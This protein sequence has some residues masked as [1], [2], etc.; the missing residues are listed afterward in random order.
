MVRPPAGS[1]SYIQKQKRSRKMENNNSKTTNEFDNYFINAGESTSSLSE[2]S[3]HAA[4]KTQ[5]DSQ[6]LPP[7]ASTKDR[8]FA[9]V[10][11]ALGFLLFELVLFEGFGVCVPVYMALFY[12]A[13]FWYFNGKPGGINAKS[14]PLLI[15]IALLLVCYVL[16]DNIVLSLLNLVLLFTLTVLQVATM[17]G[18]RLYKHFSVGLAIDLFHAGVALP[19]VNIPVPFKVLKRTGNTLGK[20]KRV[21][22]VLIGLAISVPLL[23]IVLALLSSADYVFQKSLHNV[24]TFINKHIAEYIIKIILGTI[25]AIP[26]FGALF[27]LR[28]NKKID[29]MKREINFDKVK[30]LDEGI[31]NTVLILLSA[32]YLV[33]IAVQFGYLFNAFVS[34]LPKDFTYSSYAR[35]GFFQLLAVVCINLCLLLA[36]MAF[37]KRSGHSGATMLKVMETILVAL[38]LFLIASAFSKMVLYIDAYG[39]SLLRVYTSWFMLLCAVVFI[40]MLVKLYVKKFALTRFCSIA[41][42]TLFLALNFANVDAVIPQYNIYRYTS[43]IS[44]TVDVAIFDDLSDSMIPY[45]VKVLDMG[46]ATAAKKAKELLSYRA[47]ILTDD[48]W[49]VFTFAKHNAKAAMVS[50]KIKYDPYYSSRE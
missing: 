37:S 18:N 39:L 41:F 24:L 36:S 4:V 19:L 3:Q 15:P 29:A 9:F 21:S 23:I 43:H 32:V 48:R 30:F 2:S 11:L 22:P 45:A 31:M 7:A 8:I 46:D 47:S 44:K 34:I 13:V 40:A 27:A 5:D 12:A 25:A 1:I 20:G 42:L 10:A 33:F 26:L 50:R 6:K 14:L 38:T 16:Y 28:S 35:R 17:S 49:Q